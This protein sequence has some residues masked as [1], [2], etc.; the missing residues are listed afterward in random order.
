MK[1]FRYTTL[2][3]M[4]ALALIACAMPEAPVGTALV[5]GI[6]IYQ[7]AYPEG[8]GRSNNLTYTDDDALAMS[9][10]LK[11]HG[12]TVKAGIA[13]TR[14][15]SESQD[16]TSSAMEADIAALA[17]T[18]DLVL[19]YYSGHGTYDAQ[20]NTYIIPF[21]AIEN[22]ADM[23][24]ADELLRMFKDN[25]IKNVVIMLDSCHS[26]GFVE[27]GATVDAV[28]AKFG[29]YDP[30][31]RVAPEGEVAYAWFVDSLNDAF[32]GYFLH[33][34]VSGAVVLAAAGSEEFSWESDGHGIFTAAVL[35][36]ME[37]T[38]ADYDSDGYVSTGELYAYC[39]LYIDAEWNASASKSYSD[40]QY[41]D[42]LPHLSGTAR[43]YALWA[44][45]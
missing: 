33:S 4:V 15:A 11:E 45:N 22:P 32:E 29:T 30:L 26:G 27:T 28:P 24:S 40:G 21:G 16:A 42:Y 37:S 31:G 20:G 36:A 25:G 44:T 8:D 14:T 39:F 5:Y 41:A 2:I 7:T 17:G 23:I 19:F 13:N 9:A 35:A 1:R 18:E 6:S 12:W 38:D 43:E 10:R 34:A 3:G